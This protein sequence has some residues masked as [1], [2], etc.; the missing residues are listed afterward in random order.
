[1]RYYLCFAVMN[2]IYLPYEMDIFSFSI[3]AI[4]FLVLRVSIFYVTKFI[5]IVYVLPL[6]GNEICVMLHLCPIIAYD[7][8]F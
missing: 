3:L 6:H 8:P 2:Y 7:C 1:M 5:D 4:V